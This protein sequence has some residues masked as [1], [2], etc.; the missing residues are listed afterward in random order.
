LCPAGSYCPEGSANMIPC[1][2]G[3]NCPQGCAVPTKRI[4]KRN[5]GNEG[6]NG[7]G[8]GNGGGN[9]D[10]A[11]Y[12]EGYFDEQ[13]SGAAGGDYYD[14]GKDANHE[15]CYW[16]SITP[17]P[18]PTVM[19]AN[20]SSVLV[21]VEF[22][23]NVGSDEDV[24]LFEDDVKARG[25]VWSEIESQDPI[26]GFQIQFL[27]RVTFEGKGEKYFWAEEDT[28]L[29]ATLWINVADAP[30]FEVEGISSLEETSTFYAY[31]LDELLLVFTEQGYQG[32]E[33]LLLDFEEAYLIRIRAENSGGV[34]EWSP[35]LNVDFAVDSWIYEASDMAQPA[36]YAAHSQGMDA[37]ILQTNE[38]MQFSQDGQ[39]GAT[40]GIEAEEHQDHH[41]HARKAN[42]GSDISEVRKSATQFAEAMGIFRS[43]SLSASVVGLILGLGYV[44]GGS[45]FV[46]GGDCEPFE[47]P[48]VQRSSSLE[49]NPLRKT[50]IYGTDY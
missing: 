43:M 24:F 36:A 18:S 21:Y 50:A 23:S 7:D 40:D 35:V 32:K 48:G 45:A 1:P 33:Y 4:R 31:T 47:E 10:D 29:P 26:T 17:T 34:G 16:C 3:Y 2:K 14:D 5:N 9:D 38:E 8:S 27:E 46:T 12:P 39:R 25:L 28:I 13:S 6:G 42:L 22:P 15:W 37:Y 20:A 30:A 19:P 41:Q 11:D 49:E 44:F